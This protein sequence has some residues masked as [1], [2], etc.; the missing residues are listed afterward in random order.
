MTLASYIRKR[1]WDGLEGL[2]QSWRR[3]VCAP[4]SQVGALR[5]DF[6]NFVDDA[7]A[8]F[9]TGQPAPLIRLAA[10]YHAS[11][12]VPGDHVRTQ[13]GVYFSEERDRL[14]DR[15]M[16]AMSLQTFGWML[17]R[18][19]EMFRERGPDQE[20]AMISLHRCLYLEN[21]ADVPVPKQ[22]YWGKDDPFA[23][24]REL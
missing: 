15:R 6:R 9:V 22:D 21:T 17:G 12:A 23:D 1:E 7:N 20:A 4:G 14:L 8:Q 19:V 24:A 11:P 13:T 3:E 10:A 18:Y 5:A 2:T 16:D